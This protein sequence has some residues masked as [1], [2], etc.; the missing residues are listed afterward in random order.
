VPHDLDT[1]R[2]RRA[3]YLQ[4]GVADDLVQHALGRERSIDRRLVRVLDR[5][6]GNAFVAANPVLAADAL[7]RVFE[8]GMLRSIPPALL[9]PAERTEVLNRVASQRPDLVKRFGLLI[10]ALIAPE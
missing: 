8:L 6:L 1:D 5:V 10:R 3:A 7:V 4:C 9:N 2:F